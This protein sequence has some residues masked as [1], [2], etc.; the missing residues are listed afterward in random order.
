MFESENLTRD[1][2]QRSHFM[3]EQMT[4]SSSFVTGAAVFL[5][6]FSRRI[7][8]A[9]SAIRKKSCCGKGAKNMESVKRLS[10]WS[11]SFHVAKNVV[12]EASV[13]RVAMS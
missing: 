2:V 8:P 10:E 12:K 3:D 7:P 4:H 6:S 11:S 9:I 1:K 5:P 13:F